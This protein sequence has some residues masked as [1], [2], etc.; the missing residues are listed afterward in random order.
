MFYNNYEMIQHLFFYCTLA[1]FIWRIIQLIFRL[2]VPTTMRNV[3]GACVQNMNIRSKHLLYIG[4]GAMFWRM[5]LRRND[6]IFNKLLRLIIYIGYFQIHSLDMD[7]GTSL[8]RGKLNN[9]TGCL[10]NGRNH[11]NESL[12]QA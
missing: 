11:D 4:I 1:K 3:F 5:W 10:Q 12:R 7:M 8:D 9:T 6:N 2:G